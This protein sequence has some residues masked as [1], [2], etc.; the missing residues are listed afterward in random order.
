[1]ACRP[2]A[3]PAICAPSAVLVS[4]GELHKRCTGFKSMRHYCI[5]PERLHIPEPQTTA[6]STDCR[7]PETHQLAVLNAP[8]LREVRVRSPPRASSCHCARCRRPGRLPRRRPDLGGRRRGSHGGHRDAALGLI[9]IR[10][11]R[12][13]VTDR[14]EPAIEVYV[15]AV[16]ARAAGM[17]L[18]I[19]LG[20][21]RGR[22]PGFSGVRPAAIVEGYQQ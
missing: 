5:A 3:Y 20:V 10:V 1:M 11:L 6:H 8:L 15:A 9:L 19:V 14:F 13:G 17:S 16:V 2:V 7:A 22:D 4:R 21:G 12:Q 18:G